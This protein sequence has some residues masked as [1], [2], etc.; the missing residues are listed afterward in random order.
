MV[1]NISR[2]FIYVLV[3]IILVGCNNKVNILKVGYIS[4]EAYQASKL[5]RGLSIGKFNF[6]NIKED[7]EIVAT[8][9]T[10]DK[11]IDRKVIHTKKDLVELNDIMI[12][13]N[14]L[15]VENNLININSLTND[16]I[17]FNKKLKYN[18]NNAP[19][20]YVKHT[21]IDKDIKVDNFNE[22]RLLLIVS[23]ENSEVDDIMDINKINISGYDNTVIVSLNKKN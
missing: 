14:D 1:Y 20:S 21:S 5:N 4:D 22:I 15:N 7:Y 17:Y 6:N 23:S 3:L 18:V 13:I 10:K 2:I 16:G 8:S 9:Y 11:I 19:L 12:S